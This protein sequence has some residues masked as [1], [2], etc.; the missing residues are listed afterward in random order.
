MWISNKW[1]EDAIRS[2]RAKHTLCMHHHKEDMEK[3]LQETN[4]RNDIHKAC[5]WLPQF[6]ADT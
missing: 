6:M 4:I 3:K 2:F 5:A 1:K